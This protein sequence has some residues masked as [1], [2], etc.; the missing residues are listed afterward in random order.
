MTFRGVLLFLAVFCSAL[1][2]SAVAA[3]A[4]QVIPGRH[5][6]T[7]RVTASP[8]GI[9]F[10]VSHDPQE[11]QV[12][13]QRVR[14]QLEARHAARS[15]SN[16]AQPNGANGTA[17]GIIET[18]A[19]AVPFQ[20]PVNALKTGFG[21]LQ[22][23]AEDGSG[24]LYIAS[25]DLGVVLK[26]DSSSNTTVYAGQP[27]A[28]GPAVSSGDG[29]PAT[30]ARLSCPYDLVFDGAGDL[31][32][33][34][35]QAGAVRVVQGTTGIIQ[36]IAGNGAPATAALLEGPTGLALDG[37]GNLFIADFEYVQELNL[38]TGIIQTIAGSELT[39]VQCN[40]SASN[41]CPAAQVHLSLY[42]SMAVFQNHLYAGLNAALAADNQVLRG[43]IVSIDLSTGVMQL[44][45]GGGTYAGTS[46]TYP[47][48]GKD[49]ALLGL[50]ADEKGN[51]YFTDFSSNL[52]RVLA[53]SDHTVSVVA[54]SSS[55]GYSGDGG[56]ATMATLFGPV[57]I[58][59][60]PKGDVVFVDGLRVRSFAVGGNITT[61]AGDGFGN[62]F[63]DGG[64]ATQAGLDYPD[65]F[66]AD[67]EGNIYL[68]DLDNGLVRRIDSVSGVIT[69]V[70]GDGKIGVAGD[71]GPA[72]QASLDPVSLAL[73][74]AGHLYVSSDNAIRVVDLKTGTIST[75]VSGVASYGGMVF[76]GD[77]TLYITSRRSTPNSPGNSQVLAVD[78]TTGATSIV[79][80]TVY[81]GS[82][83]GDG[84]PAT[85]AGLGDARGLA[86]DGKGTLFIADAVFNNVRSVNLSTGIIERFAGQAFDMPGPAPDG[87]DGGQAVHAI[88]VYPTGLA[89][90]GAGHLIIADSGNNLL[91]EIDLSNN[92]ITTLAGNRTAGF[93]GDGGAATGAMLY[94]PS[95]VT[96]DPSGNL[97]VADTY[98]NRV[99]RVVLHPT[100]LNAIL[101]YAGASSGGVT[102]TA[103]YSGLS[104][105]IA[106]TGTVAFL[107]GSALLGTGTIAGPADGSGGY[108][109]TFTSS[110]LPANGDTI[111]AQY[112]GDGNYAAGAITITLQ[113]LTPSYTVSATPAS[114]TIK[115]GASGSIAFTVTPQNGFNQAVSFQCDNSTL[116]QG[117][118]CSFSPASVTSNGTVAVTSTLTVATTGAAVA[119]LD[120]RT[121]NGFG[122]LHGGAVL[123]LL[124]FGIPAAPRRFWSAVRKRGSVLMLVILSICGGITI[125]GGIVGC[126]GGGSGNT[127]GGSTQAANATPPGAYAI[128][129]TTSFGSTTDTSPVTVSLTVTQ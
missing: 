93:G 26:V 122:W 12:W 35:V 77:K 55:S 60:S 11:W 116:P 59:L 98:N 96:S 47:G 125:G 94:Y 50:T 44:L 121:T 111:T 123:A 56:P 2:S 4:G 3:S 118:T 67:T 41:T 40:L 10:P 127:G 62:Y 124:L 19:G 9:P 24:N 20:K 28:T 45:A 108:V 1:A 14:A 17:A 115:Q 129:V 70:A 31:Y 95:A 107:N 84:G 75:L 39:G 90:D 27:L 78:A 104:F 87:G 120:R 58:C 103:T 33:A 71:G 99:R 29:R 128:Q 64:P 30:S 110:S 105:G 42:G 100:K 74:Q 15:Q 36:T 16:Q 86:L 68:A 8:F 85:Q 114:L 53:A 106:P 5:E 34:D 117:V 49:Y 46:S 119:A 92:I 66:A 25:C 109:A 72:L 38:S 81:T 6:A 88:L 112:S 79:A 18:I 22:G 43:A 80:G 57:A 65:S 61:V 102:F 32:I 73:D 52:V 51:V 91:R 97:F 113:Q 48:I 23:I 21:R 83:S 126:G 63:G 7:P 13:R 101:R 89:Y 37:M 76:D 54:G 69:T 82:P